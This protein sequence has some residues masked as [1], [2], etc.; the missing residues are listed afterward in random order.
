MVKR[1]ADMGKLRKK[2]HLSLSIL[3]KLELLQELDRD[4]SVRHLT[5]EYNVGTTIVYDLKKRK[6]KFYSDSDDHKLI[7]IENHG[8]GQNEYFDCVMTEWI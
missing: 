8:I 2:M 1:I 5:E 7:K 3:Q 6:Y 4:V